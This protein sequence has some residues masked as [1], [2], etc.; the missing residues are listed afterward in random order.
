MTI[1]Q[2][3]YLLAI[4]RYKS[5]SKAAEKC[6]VTQPTL[7]MQIQNLESELE[8]VLLDRSK[9]PIQPTDNGLKIIKQAERII[10]EVNI[11]KEIQKESVGDISGEL[12]IGI[13]PTISSF[14]LPLFIKEFTQKYSTVHLR[15]EEMITDRIVEALKNDELDIGIVATPLN[16]KGIHEIPIYEEAMLLYISPSSAMY[17]KKKINVDDLD[18]DELWLLNKGHCFRS[19]ILHVCKAYANRKE[20]QSFTFESGSIDTLIKMVDVHGGMTLVPELILPY[21]QKEQLKNIRWFNNPIPARQISIITRRVQL[22]SR[23]IEVLKEEIK[24]GVELHLSKTKAL[25]VIPIIN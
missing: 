2:L 4:Y 1:V 19:Q 15:T 12:R 5:F 7:S 10:L 3:E 8:V 14:L 16:E 21:L 18:V 25:N 9:K 23:Q 20:D 11:L 13:I 22:K 6:F 17:S 24:S